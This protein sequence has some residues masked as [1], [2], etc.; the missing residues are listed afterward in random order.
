MLEKWKEKLWLNSCRYSRNFLKFLPGY[1]VLL[2]MVANKFGDLRVWVWVKVEDRWSS[3]KR[4]LYSQ[5]FIM[6]H[7]N[8]LSQCLK[9]NFCWHPGDVKLSNFFFS[10]FSETTVKS[11]EVDKNGKPL[12]FLSVPQ[13]KV[14]SFGQLARLLLIAKNT[15]LQEA[16]ACVEGDIY[17]PVCNLNFLKHNLGGNHLL[18]SLE[19]V[20]LP[21]GKKSY[22]QLH[23]NV[24]NFPWPKCYVHIK[25]LL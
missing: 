16:Q 4:C 10:F 6:R 3:N 19:K 14:R 25:F 17:T 24:I 8:E 18:Q 9:F 13:I 5:C 12:L 21:K 20:L 15:K 1:I 7:G 2:T 23:K 22:V 11:E